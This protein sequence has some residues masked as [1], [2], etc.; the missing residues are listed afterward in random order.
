[1]TNVE[2]G[3]CGDLDHHST[4]KKLN[5]LSTLKKDEVGKML[6]KLNRHP[7]KK[8]QLIEGYDNLTEDIE[9]LLKLGALKEE[10]QVYVNFTFLDAEDSCFIFEECEPFGKDLSELILE[11]KDDIFAVLTQYKNPQ[12]SKEKLAFFIIGCYLLDW[13]SLEL[14][15]M[16]DIANHKKT[17]PG[18]NEYTLWGEEEVDQMLK[19]I[20]WGGHALQTGDYMFHTFGDHHKYT[21]R[22]ALP[23]L[24]HVFPDFDFQGGDEL[25][26]LLFYKRKELAIELGDVLDII[27]RERDLS[28]EKGKL[29]DFLKKIDYIE[30]QSGF[31]VNIPYFTEE[32]VPII[33]EAIKPI[34]PEL[35]KW[36]DTKIPTLEE[37]LKPARPLQNGVP[38]EEVFIQ[39]WHVVFGL[40]NKYLTEAGM[41]YDTYEEGKGYM[42]A[43]FKGKIS[44]MVLK[45]IQDIG[46]V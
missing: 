34:I 12:V 7:M 2:F 11:R 13:G 44:K 9:K 15:R 37:K 23:D 8:G 19:R 29:L 14:F 45:N 22:N 20:Y 42:P 10:E 36:V 24:L 33:V 41:F 43:L 46:I 32:E 18:G 5:P 25:K 6:L 1:M 39:V 31:K 21:R 26:K 17:Q 28:D 40:T 38:F 30:N 4:P 35:R 27:Y 16:W 3:I